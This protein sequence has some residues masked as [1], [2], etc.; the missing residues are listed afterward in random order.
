MPTEKET[1]GGWGARVCL[2]LWR[3]QSCRLPQCGRTGRQSAPRHTCR[4]GLCPEASRRVPAETQLLP[5]QGSGVGFFPVHFQRLLQPSTEEDDCGLRFCCRV[6]EVTRGGRSVLEH[7]LCRSC[8][9]RVHHMGAR[10]LRTP[11]SSKTG[12]FSQ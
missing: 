9:F 11:Y 8:M 4:A 6:E 7:S 5:G 2:D 12:L 3:I 10:D 1:Q